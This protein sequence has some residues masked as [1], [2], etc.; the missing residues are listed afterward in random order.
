MEDIVIDRET[1]EVRDPPGRLTDEQ[2]EFWSDLLVDFILSRNGREE[3][4]A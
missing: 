3:K 4:T 2:V 1:G